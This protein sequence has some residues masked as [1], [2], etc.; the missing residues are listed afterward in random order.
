MLSDDPAATLEE[1]GLA[2]RAGA[3]AEQMGGAVAYAAFLRMARFHTSNEFGDWDTVH[4]TLTAASVELLRA[5]F[6]TAIS[7]YLE[8]F[9]NMP[10]QRLPEPNGARPSDDLGASLLEA[11]DSQQQVEQVARIVTDYVTALP[12]PDGLL[13]VL[14]HAMLRE[15][16]TFHHFQIV[17]AALKQYEERKGTD[18]ARQFLVGAARNCRTVILDTLF[19]VL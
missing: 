2:V 10:P 4:N 3:T 18:A 6:D 8:R 5:V 19:P 16:S 17:D 7:I 11:M 14:A 13:S 1:L 9:L 15:D 12:R